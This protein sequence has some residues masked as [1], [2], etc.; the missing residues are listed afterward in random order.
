MNALTTGTII[1][2]TIIANAPALIGDNIPL[3]ISAALRARSGNRFRLNRNIC[4][5]VIPIPVIK[6]AQT[7]AFV[8]FFENK[9]YVKVLRMSLQ[10]HPKKWTSVLKYKNFYLKL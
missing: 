8:I 1:N 9:P 3:L 2:E 6:L 5:T 10:E 4:V 7:E